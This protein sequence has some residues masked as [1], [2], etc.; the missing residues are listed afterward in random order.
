MDQKKLN[1]IFLLSAAGA[2]LLLCA[3]ALI[4]AMKPA[5]AIA[6][7]VVVLEKEKTQIETIEAVELTPAPTQAPALR[8]AVSL[9]VD[10]VSVFTLES[11]E[12]AKRLLWDYLTRCAVAP[13]N[14]QFVS[15]AYD[16]EIMLAPVETYDEPVPYDAALALLVNQPETIPVRVVTERV[17]MTTGA[18]EVTESVDPALVKND[19]VITQLGAGAVTSV[20]TQVVYRAGELL[21][22]ETPMTT[23]LRVSRATII[24]TGGYTSEKPNGTAER[25]AGKQGKSAGEIRF[26]YPMRGSIAAYFGFTAGKMNNGL[27]IIAAAGT[28]VVAPAEGVVIYCG[29]RGAYG[30][31]VDVDHG[32]GFVSRLTHLENVQVE[33][34]Q[35]VFLGDAI[36]TLAAGEN[37]K[38]SKLH[39]ELL[40]D[41][42]PY[43][44]TFYLP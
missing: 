38:K 10:R 4:R 21:A 39:Y 2:L 8:Q 34:N 30:F 23:T 24:K 19:R 31:V 6:Q 44:P 16:C 37:A 22:E 1:R 15:A 18:S 41:G 43:D 17:S 3:A 33:R 5:P 27:D 7:E 11:E 40:I 29:E 14:E 35:R 28:Q 25:G 13:A 20:K 12:A 26:G 36:G 42:V 9:L 32:N